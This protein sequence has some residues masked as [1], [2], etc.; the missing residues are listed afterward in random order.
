MKATT[1]L[2]QQIKTHSLGRSVLLSMLVGVVAGF[3]ALAFNFVLNDASELFM[4][5]A[6]GYELPQP[7][8]EG[9]TKM[10][11]YHDRVPQRSS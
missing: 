8:A 2:W 9:V 7:G 6:V 5:R 11:T 10:P 4:V 1:R 3:G